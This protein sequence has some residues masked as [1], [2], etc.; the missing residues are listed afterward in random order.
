AAVGRNAQ[1]QAFERHVQPDRR[2]VLLDRRA[3]L[4]V[5][6]RPAAGGDHGMPGRDLLQQHG[7]LRGAGVG[8]AASGEDRCHA[9]PL[10]LLDQLVDINETPSEAA[11]ER[12]GDRR[13]A[14]P[15]E[16]DQINLVRSHAAWALRL[17]AAACRLG[18]L[19]RGPGVSVPKPKT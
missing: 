7:S 12:A 3:V 5:D 11:R 10:A 19:R 17:W 8:L 6:E 14:A 16:A 2:T 15:H 18:M 9:L 13:L 1:N 4:R